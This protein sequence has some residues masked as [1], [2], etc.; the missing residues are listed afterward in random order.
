MAATFYDVVTII[1]ISLA[2]GTA[3]DANQK[4]GNWGIWFIVVAITGVFGLFA[5]SMANMTNKQIDDSRET[6]RVNGK[7]VDNN[8]EETMVSL[9]VQT[10]NVDMAIQRF[11]AKCRDE[12]YQLEGEPRVEIDS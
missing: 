8:G 7:V 3:W 11:K 9:P 4:G 5:Y 2:I 12:G 6:V 10:A 1:W